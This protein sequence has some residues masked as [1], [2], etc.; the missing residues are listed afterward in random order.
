[1]LHLLQIAALLFFGLNKSDG[2]VDFD[3]FLLPK[4]PK[5]N[6]KVS[7]KDNKL[8]IASGSGLPCIAWCVSFET[9]VEIDNYYHG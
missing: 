4:A 9:S 7:I 2:K 1:M 6:F 5:P 8:S 3:K